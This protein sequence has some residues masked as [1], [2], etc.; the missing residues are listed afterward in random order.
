MILAY[1]A[2]VE[3]DGAHAGPASPFEVNFGLFF[4]TWV[5]FIT[6][7]FL[8]KRFAWP[9]ILKVTEERERKIAHQL[10]EVERL[11]ADAKAAAEEQRKLLAEAR[12]VAQGIM[13]EAKSFAEKERVV[14]MEKARHEA[15]D[16]VDRARREIA[17]EKEK[18]VNELR[19]EAV[20][21]SIA[22]AIKLIG[23]RLDTE[24]DRKLVQGYLSSLEPGH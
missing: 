14:T 6:L 22:A 23:Q 15:E 19:R 18:A 21:L 3:E 12:S 17:N 24:A 2:L 1:L 4:W 5:V 13:A 20:D 16:L 9:S 8:L 10:A 11:N 7:F